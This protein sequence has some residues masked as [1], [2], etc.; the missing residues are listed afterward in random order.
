LWWNVVETRDQRG[1]YERAIPNAAIQI[2]RLTASLST[3][4]QR[5]AG[6]E[7]GGSLEWHQHRAAEL[8]ALMDGCRPLNRFFSLRSLCSLWFNFFALGG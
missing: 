2:V 1:E 6:R 4:H 7:S 8:T 3:L 5:L